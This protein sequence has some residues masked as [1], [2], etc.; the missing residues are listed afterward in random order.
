MQNNRPSATHAHSFVVRLWWEPGLS[1]LNG[2]PLW[3]GYVQHAASGRSLVFQTLGDLLCFIQDQTG[4]L[5]GTGVVGEA[6][7]GKE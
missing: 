6:N 7:K 3:R 2:G 4:D 5:E 1:R